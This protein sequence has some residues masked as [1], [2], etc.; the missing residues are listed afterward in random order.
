MKIIAIG[1]RTFVTALRLAGAEGFEVRSDKE[2]YDLLND[3]INKRKDIGL[4][5]IPSNMASKYRKQIANLRRRLSLPVIY[6]L[7]PPIGKHESI[8]YKSLLRDLLG[9]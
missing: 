4:I 8:D 6:E 5:V 9:I 1:D 2:F 7:P 3:L